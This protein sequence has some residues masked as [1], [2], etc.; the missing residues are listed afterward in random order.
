[1]TARASDTRDTGA[2]RRHYEVERELADRLRRAPAEARRE[3][4]R[5]VYNELFAR[6]PDHPQNV[7]KETPAQQAARAA[8]QLRLLRPFLSTDSVY[9]EIGAGDGFVTRTVARHVRFAYG[10]DVSDVIAASADRPANFAQLISDGT[11]IPVAD[12]RVTVAF[13]NMLL[14]H[15]HPDDVDRHL[16]EVVRVLAPGGVYVCRTPHRYDGP[17]D[18]SQYF[19]RDATGLHLKEYSFREL[20]DRFR[21][22]GFAAVGV[23]A[24]VKGRAVPCPA[25]AMRAAEAALGL[26]PYRARKRLCQSTPLRP[27]FNCVTVVGRK[28]GRVPARRNIPAQSSSGLN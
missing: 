15:L 3:L 12:G 13:S 7:R 14:E 4:Y 17:Q 28:D 9:L 1:M 20:A 5:S 25:W 19:D 18:I 16:R 24:R 8:E 23:R 22:A 26:V 6:V 27:L 11:G 10:V 21:A 2:I